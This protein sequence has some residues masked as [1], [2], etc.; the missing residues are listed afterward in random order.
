MQLYGPL[1][2]DNKLQV[3]KRTTKT[4]KI[5]KSLKTLKT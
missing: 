2:D 5:E 4:K 3:T 1:N